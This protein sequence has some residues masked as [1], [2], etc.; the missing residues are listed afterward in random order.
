MTIAEFITEIHKNSAS[1]LRS[2]ATK[3]DLTLSQLTCICSI[4]FDGIKQTDLA[5]K[6][7]LDISTLS[8][9]L[10]KLI[11]K[12]II[13]KK[14]DNIDKRL[15]KVFLT[16]NGMN[17]YSNLMADLN[18]NLNNFST[19]LNENELQDFIDNLTRFNWFLMQT[20]LNDG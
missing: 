4:P 6:I 17:L 11:N 15:S 13:Y 1:H 18:N 10:D 19:Q 8:R 14:T 20:K 12:K 2:I 16:D 3:Y 5:N 7:S 9:N